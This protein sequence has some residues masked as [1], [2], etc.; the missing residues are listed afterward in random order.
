MCEKDQTFV[1]DLATE[2]EKVNITEDFLINMSSRLDYSEIVAWNGEILKISPLKSPSKSPADKPLKL[3]TRRKS[4]SEAT[5]QSIM[6]DSQAKKT[7]LQ[8][9]FQLSS[10]EKKLPAIGARTMVPKLHYVQ[11]PIQKNPQCISSGIFYSLSESPGKN[12]EKEW[13][14]KGGM[15]KTIHPSDLMKKQELLYEYS[16]IK[17]VNKTF[18]A[19]MDALRSPIRPRNFNKPLSSLE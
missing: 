11:A 2:S 5:S 4:D 15:R 18:E 14:Q 7:F 8:Q 9:R 16:L 1:Q 3:L 12:P 13:F 6:H 17:P 10:R 19:S